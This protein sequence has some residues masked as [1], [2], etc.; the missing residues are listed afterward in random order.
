[1]KPHEWKRGRPQ[2]IFT[3]V[4][5]EAMKM[6]GLKKKKKKW[7]GWWLMFMPYNKNITDSA[8]GVWSK[9]VLHTS[10]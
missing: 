10:K 8:V 9:H 4:T 6:G 5:K 7:N 3:D 2:R 1:M